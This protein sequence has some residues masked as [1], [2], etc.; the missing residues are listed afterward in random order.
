MPG[1]VDDVME[2]AL[3][4]GFFWPAYLPY[5]G[6]AGLYV[7]GNL[8]VKLTSNISQM[9]REFFIT[10]Y[11]FVEVDTPSLVPANVLEASGHVSNFKDP[12]AECGNC[13]RRYR[14]D[15]L[16]KES[17]SDI[18][19]GASLEEME[20]TLNGEKVKC[21]QCSSVNW[22]VKPFL[23]MFETKLG[24]YTDSVG[25]LRPETAQGTFVEFRRILETERE[26]MPLGVAQ[27]G[28]GFRNE[29]SPRQGIIRLRELHM[30]ELE[31]FFDPEEQH[32]PYLS[33]LNDGATMRI[34]T[35]EARVRGET[36]PREISVIEALK[37]GLVK[38]EWLAY[39]MHRSELFVE[40][41][42]VPHK[43]IR[44]VE[45]LREER[46]HY[47]AQT[48]D[49]EV[50]MGELG[51]VEVAGLAYR[52]DFDL[53]SHMAKTGVDLT[54]SV[55]LPQPVRRKVRKWNINVEKVKKLYPKDWKQIMKE[56]S[57]LK[58]REGDPPGSISGFTLD[59]SVFDIRD[60]EE[61]TNVRKFIPHVVEPAFG[62]E[63]LMLASLIHAYSFK[64][65]RVV[66]RLPRRV[67]PIDAAVFP[68]VS[69]DAM[70]KD[71]IEI[72]KKLR[73]NGLSVFYDESGAIGRRYA[74][75]DEVGIPFAVTVDG[76]TEQ[77]GTVTLRDR[78]SWIQ[79]RVPKNELVK[80]IVRRKHE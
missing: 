73:D 59:A 51:W 76:Q 3:R 5:G 18:G 64:E 62:V 50:E 20:R 72:A 41:L 34:L 30:M 66:L 63:R 75:A 44:Y 28:R 48:F 21:P 15:H 8:G 27:V 79:V 58:N 39:L 67:A 57:S 70:I 60:V 10:P 25:Y 17:G 23:T 78:D 14:A 49:L 32:C 55:Q 6:A 52:T 56:I 35:G 7:L 71:A 54:A 11:N 22:S 1:T 33:E 29:I 61:V 24:P 47:S 42:G 74:R 2:L 80:E 13:H 36:V 43:S 26:R 45:K 19:E 53:R 16:L 40:A 9:W 68:L 77:D 38:L 69:K 65:D 31:L 4:R 46:A 37:E 12:M